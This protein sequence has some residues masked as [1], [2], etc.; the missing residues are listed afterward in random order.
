MGF[1][2]YVLKDCWFNLV[3]GI[4]ML[5]GFMFGMVCGYILK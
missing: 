2:F 1:K 4:E 3:V 5:E